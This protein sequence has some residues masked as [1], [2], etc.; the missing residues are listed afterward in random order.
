[1][2]TNVWFGFGHDI[3]V[4][5]AANGWVSP[6][7]ALPAALAAVSHPL[8]LA[9]GFA[10]ALAW[11]RSRRDAE[12]EDVLALLALIF[13][14]RCLLDPMTNSYYHLPFLMSLAAW[15]GLRRERAPLLTVAA[16]LLIALTMAFGSGGV[17]GAELNRLYLAWALPLA[18]TLGLLAFRRPRRM[19]A[20]EGRSREEV[21]RWAD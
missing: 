16:T 9:C 17:P 14:V 12:P 4:V 18:A 5:L 6:P 8:I 21:L 1:M 13:L 2:P 19:I 7:R 20:I 11:W 15:E 3:P 10:L